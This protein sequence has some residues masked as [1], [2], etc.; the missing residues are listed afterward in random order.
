MQ[1]SGSLRHRI[2]G[3]TATLGRRGYPHIVSA[4]GG[5]I[6]IVTGP[7]QAG[8]NPVDLLCAS[9]SACL[10]MSARIAAGE[11]GVLADMEEIAVTVEADKSEAEPF[12]I[13][14]FV[15]GLT[16]RGAIDDERKTAIL[17]RAEALC[18][19]SNTLATRPELFLRL[20]D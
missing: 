12:R 16:I 19:V 13:L 15:I 1:K 8:F 20:D 10:A 18:T 7:S 6:D 2:T 5:E 11:L 3:A 4:T 9:L 17:H 14:R